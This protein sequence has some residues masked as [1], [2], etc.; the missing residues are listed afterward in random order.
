MNDVRTAAKSR[1]V[2]SVVAL[3]AIELL[4]DAGLVPAGLAEPIQQVLGGLAVIFLY[5]RKSK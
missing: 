5:L 3:G 2:W 1:T 4:S